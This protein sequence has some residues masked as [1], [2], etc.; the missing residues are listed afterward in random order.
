MCIEAGTLEDLCE[1]YPQ[2][3]NR[4][5]LLALRRREQFKLI[6]AQKAKTKTLTPI[7][8]N[9]ADTDKAEFDRAITKLREQSEN[10]EDDDELEF[11]VD[12]DPS[13][14]EESE[15]EEVDEIEAV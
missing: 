12:F 4:L 8:F 11:G 10:P 1:L 6:A 3:A 15:E 7:S 5:K 9:E 2:T 14:L 13:E